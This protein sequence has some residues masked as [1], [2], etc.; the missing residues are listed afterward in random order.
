MSR[1]NARQLDAIRWLPCTSLADSSAS[2][3]P[4]FGCVQVMGTVV[5][6]GIASLQVTQ[7]TGTTGPF[8]LNGAFAIPCCAGGSCTQ[9]YPSVALYDTGTPAVGET[10]VPQAGQYTLTKGSTGTAGG[11][12]VEGIIDVANQ[13]MWVVGAG[14]SGVGGGTTETSTTTTIA[15]CA[16]SCRWV[17]NADNTSWSLGGGEDNCSTP[18]TTTTTTTTTTGDPSTTTTPDPCPCNT[19]TTGDPSTSTTTSTTPTP[20]NCIYPS[21]CGSTDGEC[22]ATYCASG[23]VTPQVA[24]TTTTTTSSTTSTTTTTSD[25]DCATTTTTTASPCSGCSFVLTPNGWTI[26]EDGCYPSPTCFPCQVPSDSGNLCSLAMDVPCGGPPATT[27][28]CPPTCGGCCIWLWISQIGQWYGLDTPNADWNCEGC[29]SCGVNDCQCTPPSAPGSG[30]QAVATLCQSG[31]LSTSTTTTSAPDGGGGGGPCAHCYTS[32]TTSS[33][34]TSTTTTCGSCNCGCIYQWGGSSWS[35]TVNNCDASVCYCG[36]PSAD[37]TGACEVETAQT[38]C[39]P[40]TTTTTTSTTTTTTTTCTPCDCSCTVRCS[41]GFVLT[42][43]CTGDCYCAAADY[44]GCTGTA[45][46]TGCLYTTTTSAP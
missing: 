12:I 33:T 14:G 35:Q 43:S 39:V 40:T 18:T 27:T 22:T 15:P 25:C 17:W 32:T 1:P 20:C 9:D 46:G 29:K 26:Y 8:A 7:P 16:G 28:P 11:F 34:T 36:P 30:C 41:D 24:C 37:G 21:Y 38:P 4:A 19:T 2:P 44:P 3:I 31:A 23:I 13:T 5:T 6:G 10:W 42:N 45:S